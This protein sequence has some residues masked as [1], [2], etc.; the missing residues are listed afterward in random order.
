MFLGVAG[1]LA[2]ELGAGGDQS[3]T[4]LSDALEKNAVA[5]V[6]GSPAG[7]TTLRAVLW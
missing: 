7:T 3:H 6:S 2:V 4:D 5:D 1:I